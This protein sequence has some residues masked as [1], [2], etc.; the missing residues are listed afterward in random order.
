MGASTG[1]TDDAGFPLA[2]PLNP[3]TLQLMAQTLTP[4]STPSWA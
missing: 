4:A 1:G 2:T 3:Q